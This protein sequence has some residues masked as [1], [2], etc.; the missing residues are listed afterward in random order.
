MAGAPYEDAIVAVSN[1]VNGVASTVAAYGPN[2]SGKVVRAAKKAGNAAKKTRKEQFPKWAKGG[3]AVAES[4][5]LSPLKKG[6]YTNY[7]GQQA[8]EAYQAAYD[9]VFQIYEEAM[10][11]QTAGVANISSQEY[12]E[13]SLAAQTAAAESYAQVASKSGG[14]LGATLLLLGCSSAIGGIVYLVSEFLV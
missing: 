1:A 11:A 8:E 14:C 13:S 7:V 3:K 2:D 4:L 9:R 10:A 5:G 6:I 12:L